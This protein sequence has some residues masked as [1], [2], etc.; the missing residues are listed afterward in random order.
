MDV[1]NHGSA[2]IRIIDG[3]K[4]VAFGFVYIGI[5]VLSGVVGVVLDECVHHQRGRVHDLTDFQQRSSC[6]TERFYRVKEADGHKRDVRIEFVD[7]FADQVPVGAELLI[8]RGERLSERTNDLRESAKL[9]RA[10]DQFL[11]H[12]AIIAVVVDHLLNVFRDFRFRIENTCHGKQR[13]GEDVV[14]ADVQRDQIGILHSVPNLNAQRFCG[15]LLNRDAEIRAVIRNGIVEEIQYLARRPTGACHWIEVV[16][17]HRVRN[18]RVVGEGNAFQTDI[19][20]VVRAKALGNAV[21]EADV[22][23]IVLHVFERRGKC[24]DRANADEHDDGQHQRQRPFESNFR[25]HIKAP[26]QV[27]CNCLS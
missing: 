25:L 23:V 19:V 8:C 9:A 10:K 2:E 7:A 3:K 13:G 20:R 17:G 27:S 4:L 14:R 11:K 16:G 18:K 1:G 5:E 22:G 12:L 6:Q 15:F 26:L 21:A 24:A